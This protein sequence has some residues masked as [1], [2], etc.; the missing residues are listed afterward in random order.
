MVWIS[1]VRNP[2]T[3]TGSCEVL[4]PYSESTFKFL[5]YLSL[6]EDLLHVCSTKTAILLCFCDGS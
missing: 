3:L 4:L 2:A 5:C 1:G 6:H